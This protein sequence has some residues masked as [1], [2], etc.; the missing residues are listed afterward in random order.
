MHI[1]YIMMYVYIY[2]HVKLYIQYKHLIMY[3]YIYIDRYNYIYLYIH[4][5]D[6]L[7]IEIYQ[8]HWSVI[9]TKT[10]LKTQ[11]QQWTCWH[12]SRPHGLQFNRRFGIH[13]FCPATAMRPAGGSSVAPFLS[14]SSSRDMEVPCLPALGPAIQANDGCGVAWDCVTC[15]SDGMSLLSIK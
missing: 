3:V 7:Y 14:P 4:T 13:R 8:L 1:C 12:S 9:I 15:D 10:Y 11:T 5:N 2:I 6:R